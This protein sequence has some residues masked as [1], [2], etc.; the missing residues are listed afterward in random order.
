MKRTYHDEQIELDCNLL[1][2]LYCADSDSL[3]IIKVLMIYTVVWL[4]RVVQYTQLELIRLW[5]LRFNKPEID[6]WTLFHS[7]DLDFEGAL[8]MLSIRVDSIEWTRIVRINWGLWPRFKNE[9]G[10]CIVILRILTSSGL[11]VSPV[12]DSSCRK[13]ICETRLRAN[14]VET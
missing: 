4:M 13:S 8:K 1:Y 3:A 10:S 7:V 11:I 9:E 12:V 5:Y 2:I 14:R 6:S